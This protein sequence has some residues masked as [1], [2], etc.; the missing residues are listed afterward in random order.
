[1]LRLPILLLFIFISKLAVS[2]QNGFSL[3]FGTNYGGPLANKTLA[4]ASGKSLFGSG[5]HLSYNYNLSSKLAFVPSL[6]LD[7]RHFSY[8]AL[9]RKDTVVE[10]EMNGIVGDIDTYYQAIVNGKSQTSVG[11][12]NLLG[13]FRYS[14]RS[15][16]LF[17]AYWGLFSRRSDHVELKVLIGEG[18]F[19]PDIDS[20][21]ND[22][23]NIRNYEIGL[24]LGGR[25]YLS[26]K[27]SIDFLTTRSLTPFYKV[28]TARNEEQLGMKFF[29]TYVRVAIN[30]YLFK[31]SN[32]PCRRSGN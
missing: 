29:S 16:L 9:E 19:L 26:E 17:G 14:K 2:G 22:G 12:L 7:F 11:S 28:W 25:F 8:K 23:A 5:F 3:G 27:V 21:Y 13:E 15:T 32:C 30:F 18:G 24:S 4:N 10:V 20:T 1:M 31:N 6:T